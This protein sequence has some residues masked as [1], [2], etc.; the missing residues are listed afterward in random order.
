MLRTVR[1]HIISIQGIQCPCGG[2]QVI[3][4][5]VGHL[6]VV[7]RSRTQSSLWLRDLLMEGSLGLGFFRLKLGKRSI[8]AQ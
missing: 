6:L 8:A 5:V 7:L 2:A 1:L 4:Q 3:E